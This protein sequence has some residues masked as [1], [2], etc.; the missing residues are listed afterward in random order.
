M[1]VLV[2]G[3]PSIHHQHDLFHLWGSCC[4]YKLTKYDINR[5]NNS[6]YE[7]RIDLID[8]LH[9]ILKYQYI[10]KGCY[11]CMAYQHIMIEGWV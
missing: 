8:W 4:K 11:I 2:I 10:A 6:S 9:T 1:V 7:F 5:L 3:H